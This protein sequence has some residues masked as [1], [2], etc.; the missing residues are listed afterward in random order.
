MC[1]RGM[2][3]KVEYFVLESFVPGFVNSFGG[4]TKDYVCG[5]FVLLCVG[6]GFME[7]GE[8]SVRPST[9]PESVLVVV[10]EVV[11]VRWWLRRWLRRI[12]SRREMGL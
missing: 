7:D 12:L 10:V 11:S 1:E 3:V 8:G 4:V 9:S 5:V 2:Y 6:Y